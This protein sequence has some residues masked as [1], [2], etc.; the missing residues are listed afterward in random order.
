MSSSKILFLSLFLL[1][2]SLVCFS[3]V[4]GKIVDESNSPLEWATAA[5]YNQETKALVTGVVT[6]KQGVF[7]FENLK[8]GNYYL[9]AS[10]MGYEVNIIEDISLK[11]PCQTLDLG[12]I[13]L[14]LGN[15]LNE[16]TVKAERST[17]INKIDRQ[18]FEANKFKSAQGGSGIDVVRNL[19]SVTVDSQGEINVRGSAGFVVLLNGKPFQGNATAL[20]AQLPANAIERVEV[21]TAPSA[22]YDPEGK[23]GILNITTKKGAVD[24][25]YGLINLRGGFPSIETYGNADPHQR[26]GA[27]ATYNVRN[28]KW[29]LSLGANYQRNDIGG[30]REGDVFTIIDGVKIRFPSTGE[31]S[32]DE[33]N[34]RGRLN[35]DFT[36]DM[37]NEFSFGLFAG[38]R[39]RERLADIVYFDNHAV[40][41]ADSDNRLYT[42]QYFNH[43]LRERKSDF[44]LGSFDYAHTFRNT[45]KLSTSILY[46]YTLLGGPTVNQNLGFPDTSILYQ[47]EFNTNNNPLHGVRLQVDYTFKPFEFGSLETG[48]QYSNLD[49]TG[50]FLYERRTDFDDDF[51]LVPEFSSEVNLR[52]S[53]HAFYGQFTGNKGN[54]DYAAGARL[55]VMNRTFELKDKTNTVDETFEY[56]FTKLYPS[57]SVQYSIDEK[58]NIKA[59]YSKRVE[60]TTTFKMNPFPEREDSETLEQGDPNLRPEFIDL[61]EL[62]VNKKLD[63]GS[64]VFA[65]G[66]YRNVKNVINRVN[67][68]F[69]DTILNRIYSNVGNARAIGLE[70]GAQLKT[71]ENW[72]NFIGTNIYNYSIEG[73]FDNFPINSQATVYSINLNSTYNF[74][75]NASAQ[76]T[77]NYL[78]DRITA[79]GKDSRFYSPNLTLQ[80]SFLDNRLTVTLQWQNMD[81]GMLNSNEQ[82]ITTSRANEFFTTTN[83]I[84]EVDI[85]L[86]NLS[87]TFKNGNNK[88]KFIDSEFGKREF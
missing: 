12:R 83:Y 50:D 18:V 14:K 77:F 36:P 11:N 82:R 22:K 59:A 87:Y 7:V 57:A 13:E 32:I 1:A 23:G 76:F 56:D 29:N 38:K 67:T 64:S 45:S 39:S 10:F 48:Y 62:S 75:K 65:T 43:N 24:G 84:Y 80:K 9:E 15:Q 52:R 85:I 73:E 71:T 51:E 69:N 28:E 60:R 35:I 58:T 88:S 86:L 81:L 74:W 4:T 2:N 30:R 42:F 17:V 5:I 8:K 3:Q 16:V 63:G 41:P 55:E 49:H 54:W 25:A 37:N 20:L 44:A 31:R 79:Q 27:D 72:D 47:D 34:Y 78:S 66:Y 40:S 70:L 21:I 68:V 61:L 46:E 33:I 53:I 19:P 6:D 26:Y